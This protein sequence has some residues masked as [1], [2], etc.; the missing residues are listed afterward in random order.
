MSAKLVLL[1]LNHK[2]A[3]VE[4]RER[5]AVSPGRL[6]EVLPALR[7]TGG[8]AELVVLSTC[9]RFEVY[10]VLGDAQRSD[11]SDLVA[12]TAGTGQRVNVPAG[13]GTAESALLYALAALRGI[14]LADFAS[15]LYVRRAAEAAGHLCRV[16]CG[17]D[18]LLV[19]EYQILGQVKTAFQAAQEASST[20]PVLSALFRQA[21]HAGKRARTETEIGVGARSLGQVAVSLARQNLGDLSQRTALMVGAGK[22]SELTGR[23]LAEAGLH[24][25]LVSN[26][27]FDR[28]VAL[29]E[30][31]GGQAV[32]FD[33]LAASLQRADLVIAATG[34]PHIVLHEA[35]MAAA[36]AGRPDRSMVVIDLSVP[37]NVDPAVRSLHG[38]RL[39]DMDDLVTVVAEHHPVAAPAIAAAEGIA[40]QEASAFMGWW[41][42]RQAA[43]VI[44]ALRAQAGSVR[45]AELARALRRLGPLT[46]EQENAL[47]AF[48]QALVNKLLHTPTCR[49]K[50]PDNGHGQED[51]LA[52]VSDLFSL[53]ESKA[54]PRG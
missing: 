32:H 48:S 18:S 50:S 37:R 31:L 29:A 53:G 8:A 21:I 49:L 36:M 52:V 13:A 54:T 33:G 27:T 9:N 14:A 4:I 2:V 24:C 20:G 23:A 28:A 5:L 41:R 47:Q 43:P 22:M 10:A 25:L 38:L 26:R 45:Q 46:A 39:Y 30:S 11:G 6:S 15:Y 42:Q 51:Y 12:G 3:P 17:L 44:Q 7:E 1:G 35:D 40:A 19:G 34:A 16:A